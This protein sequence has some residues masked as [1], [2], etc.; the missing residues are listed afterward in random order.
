MIHLH[1]L[2]AIHLPNKQLLPLLEIILVTP[3]SLII[4]HLILVINSLPSTILLVL[5]IIT[6]VLW[7]R[8]SSLSNTLNHSHNLVV[9]ISKLYTIY[10]RA[11]PTITAIIPTITSITTNNII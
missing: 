8:C 4:R 3:L 5:C 6:L 7:F 11:I 9:T 10:T 1:Q 2:P